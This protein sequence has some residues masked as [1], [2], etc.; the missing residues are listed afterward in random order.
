M[1]NRI[2]KTDTL[3]LKGVGIL[4]IIFHNYFHKITPLMGQNEFEYDKQNLLNFISSITANTANSFQYILSFFGHYG[5]QFFIFCSGYGLA[6]V[7]GNQD[8]VFKF[9]DFIG[10]RI[11]KLYPV[12]TIA[13]VLLVLYQYLVLDTQVT[14]RTLRE[15]FIRYTLIANWIPGKVFIL[16]GPFWFYSMIIQLYLC[17]PL[18]L[19]LHRKSKYG[20]WIVMIISYLI[21]LSTNQYFS[22]V[23]LSLYYNFI[24]NLPV[25]ILGMILALNREWKY[26][27]W[28]WMTSVA[29]FII[30]QSNV[31]F[32]SFSQVAFVLMTVPIIVK[33]YEKFSGSITSK[34][35]VFTGG[36]SMYLFAVNGFMRMPWV[37]MSIDM[38]SKVNSLLYFGAFVL[39]VFLVAVFVKRVEGYLVNWMRGFSFMK[40]NL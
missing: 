36:L 5:V 23:G 40:K 24:G 12:F 22:S 1:N 18:L 31:Y 37:Q 34:A 4:M 33:L 7:Y 25:F 32:W 30:G 29:V 20:L 2:S 27:I 28:I 35:L 11:R 10:K 26:P 17:F 9:K 16:S 39:L 8:R 6:V 14:I 38:G 19:K 21:I 13:I 15:I 3:V